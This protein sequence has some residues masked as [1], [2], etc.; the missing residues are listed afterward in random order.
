M[1]MIIVMKPQVKRT[2][3]K[4]VL[5]FIDELGL[6]SVLMEGVERNVIAL[7]GEERDLSI[8][9]FQAMS[10]V[11]Y[12]MPV[13]K[14]YKLAAQETLGHPTI[15]TVGNVK[16]GGKNLCI[17]A[18]PCSVESE[19]QVIETA[20]AVKKSG[21]NI[22]R[23]GAFKPRT[24]PYAFQGMG[25]EGLKILQRAKMETGLPIITEIMDSRDAVL[26]DKYTDIIQIGA[27]NSQN[28]PL[29]KEVG[30][31]QRP[32]FLKRG[33]SGTIDEL[34]MSAEYIM[35][36]GNP[37]VI[38]CERGIRTY[39]TATR[40]T[41]DINAIPVLKSLTHLPVIADP[42]HG[43]GHYA[44]VKPIAKA[45]IAAGADGLMIEVHPDPK[46]AVSDGG[47]SLTPSNFEVLMQECRKVAKAVDKKM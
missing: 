36:E 4:S 38:L 5:S 8:Q 29:L 34:L 47:Q 44:Y 16:I 23:G 9:T 19:N 3:I 31:M 24:S 39:E 41:F 2:E 27:R 22:L 18:G 13:V 26:I 20:I 35:S 7:I 21:A 14:P 43:T 1:P 17:M 15:I 30:R 25:E 32:V 6:K 42:S 37:N 33:I 10:G 28:Y 11:D 45:A 40:N 46:M 12:V